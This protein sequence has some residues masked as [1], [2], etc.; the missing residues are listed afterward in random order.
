MERCTDKGREG[1]TE[2]GTEGGMDKME[3]GLSAR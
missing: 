2:V 3:F 1:G